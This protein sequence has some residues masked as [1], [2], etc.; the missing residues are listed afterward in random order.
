ML[1]RGWY[2]SRVWGFYCNGWGFLCLNL[3]GS[4]G[5]DANLRYILLFF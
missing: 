1:I 5:E 3:W 2:S 4:G